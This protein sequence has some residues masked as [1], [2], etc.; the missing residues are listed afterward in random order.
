M[1]RNNETQVEIRFRIL[2]VAN[3][4]AH[5]GFARDGRT[6]SAPT[7]QSANTTSSHEVNEK[8][9]ANRFISKL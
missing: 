4:I 7:P 8:Q 9:Q 5:P 1:F 6:K 2:L 3:I